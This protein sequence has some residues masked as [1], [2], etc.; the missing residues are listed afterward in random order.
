MKSFV[1]SKNDTIMKVLTSTGENAAA[2]SPDELCSIEQ[3]TMIKILA[4][5]LDV[6]IEK[7][8]KSLFDVPIGELSKSGARDVIKYLKH[9][10]SD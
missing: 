1:F 7:A 5:E 10:K 4:E 8:V 9:L 2:E 6:P 3:Y